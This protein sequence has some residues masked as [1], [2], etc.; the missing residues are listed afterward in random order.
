[1]ER[2]RPWPAFRI[3]A[4][5][6]GYALSALPPSSAIPWHRVVNAQGRVSVSDAN[7]SATAQRL[8]L[9]REGIVLDAAGR[10]SLT[11]RLKRSL[12]LSRVD[13]AEAL[14]LCASPETG[15]LLAILETRHAPG[16]SRPPRRGSR[17]CFVCTSCAANPSAARSPAPRSTAKFLAE[18]IRRRDGGAEGDNPLNAAYRQ[19]GSYWE[20]VYSMARYGVVHPDF[21]LE[22]AGEG[23]FLFA[24]VQP[25]LTQ[26][27]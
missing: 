12:P 7:G 26:L 13:V 8:R 19:V 21:L 20:M 2:S 9:A 27:R 3:S 1:M 10:V 15:R 4:R 23:I 18:G 6:V 5:L 14:R 24:R 22:S 17:R 25:F 16:L 11:W